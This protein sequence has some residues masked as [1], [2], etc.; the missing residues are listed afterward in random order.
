MLENKKL[1]LL[2]SFLLA[3]A[4]WFYVVGQ[5]NPLTRKTYRDIPI[6]LTNEQSLNDSGMA[7]L[8]SSDDSL[9]VTLSGK[10]DV[11]SKMSKADIVATVDLTNAAEGKNR[12]QIDLKIPDNVEIVNQS[13]NDIEVNVEERVTRT[14]DVHVV[15]QGKCPEG[16]EP[17]TIKVD[18]ENVKVSGAR[19]LVE[20]VSYVTAEVNAGDVS[21][22]LSSTTCALIPESAGGNLVRNISLSH[23]MCKVTSILY[24]TRKVKLVVPVKDKSDDGL[25]RT[26]SYPKAITVKGPADSLSGINEIKAKAIDVTEIKEN[27]KIPVD[28]VLPEEVRVAAADKNISL[29]VKVTKAKDKKLVASGDKELKSF[30]FTEDDV[31]LRNAEGMQAEAGQESLEVQI[32]GTAEQL[33]DI[34]SSDIVL[35]ADLSS[36][37]DNDTE[38]VIVAECAK[39]H[40][41][42][43]VIPSR[44]R[45]IRE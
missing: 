10:R 33:A 3:C 5:M 34:M 30:T 12:L 24:G 9:R 37:G 42:I 28:P 16:F 26:T 44:I 40:A 23:T 25:V 1:N 20:K 21:E 17:A 41:D 11:I 18:P 22:E 35:Y 36:L 27:T 13:L 2:I 29:I 8:G 31:E 43:A 14:K 7:V 39:E 15:Y 32:T 19:S 6:M 4:L 38:A 45:L